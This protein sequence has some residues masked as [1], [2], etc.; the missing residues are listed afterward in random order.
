MTS[1][2]PPMEKHYRHFFRT[3][4]NFA[5][6]GCGFRMRSYQ[7]A[8][9]K[10][11][12]YSIVENLGL[13]IVVIMPRQAGKD[14]LLAHVKAYLMRSM[15]YKDRTIVEVNP[16][17]KPQTVQAMMRLENRLEANLITRKR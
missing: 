12:L 15:A 14:E 2:A 13:D 7:A 3:F 4:Q 8:P 17:Y 5:R 10:A 1:D 9:A 6:D 16:T 11:I